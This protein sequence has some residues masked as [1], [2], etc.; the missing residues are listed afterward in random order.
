[1]PYP[2]ENVYDKPASNA[3]L[4]AYRAF[5]EFRKEIKGKR[6]KEIKFKVITL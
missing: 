5:K 1:M 4:A 3:G 6:I 2:K